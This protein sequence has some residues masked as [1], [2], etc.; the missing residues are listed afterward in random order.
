[1]GWKISF[2]CVIGLVLLASA[3][4]KAASSNDVV[5]FSHPARANSSSGQV[6]H[7]AQ[8]LIERIKIVLVLVVVL[9][10]EKCG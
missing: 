5:T 8:L 6:A 2:G 1:M 10:L 9:V 7:R 4:A 3:Q